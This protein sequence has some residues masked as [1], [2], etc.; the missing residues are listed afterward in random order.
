MRKVLLLLLYQNNN[1]IVIA[2]I[3]ES[4]VFRGVAPELHQSR[5]IYLRKKRLIINKIKLLI[6]TI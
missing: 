4:V 2:Y 6:N 1:I 3:L 5:A